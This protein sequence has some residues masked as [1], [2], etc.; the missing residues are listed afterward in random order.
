[1][2]LLTAVL[3]LAAVSF[4]CRTEPA[5]WSGELQTWGTLREALR[6]GEVEARVDTAD[7]AHVG[8]WGVGALEGLAG[9]VTIADGEV[10]VTEGDADA[11]TTRRA[12]AAEASATVLFAA[13]V[14]EWI[15]LDVDQPVDPSVLDAYVASRA[16]AAGLDVERP[17]PFVVEGELVHLN[18]HVVAGE[19]PIRARM[20][21]ADVAHR[22][23]E[24]HADSAQ[25][26]LVGLFAPDSAGIVC[27]MGSSTHTHV[28]LEGERPMTG[29][30]E[31]VGLAAGAKL[32]LPRP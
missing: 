2:K 23:Y 15:E 31:T 1:M 26:R 24:L 4:S 8:V 7:V 5:P 6:D 12:R 10:W 29:H 11:P 9:E 18:M 14:D 27:H 20:T 30:V 25:G 16:K 28:L 13:E 32:R 21:G 17:F 19:C 22:P 3:L